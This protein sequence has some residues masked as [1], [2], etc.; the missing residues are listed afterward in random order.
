MVIV[1]D[2]VLI[3]FRVAGEV[4]PGR[5]HGIVAV[6]VDGLYHEVI[7]PFVRPDIAVFVD[8]RAEDFRALFPL[9][10]LPDFHDVLDIVDR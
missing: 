8:L 2:D 4:I 6:V 5:I 10:R 9:L 3:D 7:I 1:E